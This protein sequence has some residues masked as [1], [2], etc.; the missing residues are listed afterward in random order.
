MYT[1]ALVSLLIAIIIALAT[2]T[3]TRATAGIED[4]GAAAETMLTEDYSGA[5]AELESL[6]L[7]ADCGAFAAMV[8]LTAL[9]GDRSDAVGTTDVGIAALATIQVLSDTMAEDAALQ[10][11]LS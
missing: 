11:A 8:Y 10:C 2:V 9:I 5:V 3:A 6:D 4:I 7:T 1:K